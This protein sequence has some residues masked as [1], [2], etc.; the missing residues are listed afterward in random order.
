MQSFPKVLVYHGIIP[1]DLKI[2]VKGLG[3]IS[4][5]AFF[6]HL[7]LIKKRY[8]ILHPD[9]FIGILEN[10][11]PFPKNCILITF[12]DGFQNILDYAI[13][14]TE[15]YEIPI[16]AFICDAHLDNKEWLWFSR[17]FAY[18]LLQKRQKDD[19]KQNWLRRIFNELWKTLK[20]CLPQM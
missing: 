16:L 20:I 6:D 9:E 7:T 1:D 3:I 4:Q 11:K 15:L 13:P 18:T 8:Q 2:K 5:S 10:R 17:L 14:I 19:I 12:D